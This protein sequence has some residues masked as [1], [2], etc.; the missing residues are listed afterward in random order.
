VRADLVLQR[1]AARR[2]AT[3]PG[4]AAALRWAPWFEL[5]LSWPVPRAAFS[6]RPQVDAVVLVVRRRREPLLAPAES[7]TW[8]A[9]LADHHT[10]SQRPDR[11]LGW[12]LRRY[13][14]R[15][16]AVTGRR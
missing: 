4:T 13:R 10:R 5:E 7:A 3:G 8:R 9:F 6:P 11:H 16:S 2:V 14:S 15:R 12:W 1:A